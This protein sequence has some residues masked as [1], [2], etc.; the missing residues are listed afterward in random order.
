[1]FIGSKTKCEPCLLAAATGSGTMS[2][3]H[4]RLD[5]VNLLGASSLRQIST[6]QTTSNNENEKRL[7]DLFFGVDEGTGGEFVD[8][9]DWVNALT[10]AASVA[11]SL[12]ESIQSEFCS[13]E[14]CGVA[15]ETYA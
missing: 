10:G 13:E 5:R 6:S 4:F 2:S 11:K 9:F 12:Q 3:F 14:N 15:Q 8:G 1:M 7:V